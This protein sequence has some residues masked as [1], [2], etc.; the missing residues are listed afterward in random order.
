M[1]GLSQKGCESMRM[2]QLLK[3]IFKSLKD[4]NFIYKKKKD[5]QID[6]VTALDIKSENIIRKNIHKYFPDHNII[7]EE[8]KK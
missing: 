5:F 2:Q 4:L 6:P 8:K 1:A 3:P 7:G